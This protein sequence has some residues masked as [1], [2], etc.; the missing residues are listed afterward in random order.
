MV[1]VDWEVREFQ[2][3]GNAVNRPRFGFWLKEAEQDFPRVFLVISALVGHTQRG[4]RP[5]ETSDRLRHRVE[6]L[7]GLQGQVHARHATDGPPPHARA[8]DD[9]VGADVAVSRADAAHAPVLAGDAGD[10]RVLHDAH[11]TLPRA[12]GQRH[13]NVARIGLAFA[14]QIYAA[15]DAGRVQQRVHRRRLVGRER[16]DLHAKR[17]RHGGIAAQFLEAFVRER[18]NHAAVALEA[19]RNPRFRL[20]RLVK[21]G[22]VFRQPR[23]VLRRPQLTNQSGSMPGRAAGQPLAFEQNHIRAAQLRKVV[24]DGAAHHAAADDDDVDV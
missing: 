17:A 23:H 20:Q 9:D 14:R 21:I 15:H 12:R 22:A 11:P 5:I 19:R 4:Q 7:A 3:V 13:R 8:V 16:L 24:S 6:M 2:I 18:H 1:H 10:R